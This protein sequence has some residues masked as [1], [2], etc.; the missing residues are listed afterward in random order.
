[1]LPQLNEYVNYYVFTK[2]RQRSLL[3]GLYH[4]III[5]SSTL[6]SRIS[7]PF[8]FLL[9]GHTKYLKITPPPLLF[10]LRSIALRQQ[11]VLG[12]NVGVHSVQ[13]SVHTLIIVFVL[14]KRESISIIVLTHTL[15]NYTKVFGVS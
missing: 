5:L 11:K 2:F 8:L 15:Y 4:V 6:Y 9:L 3:D 7:I 12:R 1:M 10:H 14:L 13:P